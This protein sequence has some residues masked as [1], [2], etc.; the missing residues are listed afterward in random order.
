[1]GINFKKVAETS[2]GSFDPLPEN[3]YI[4]TVENAELKTA[5]TGNEMIGVQFN[6][7]DGEF[8]GRKLWHNF[9]LTPKSYVYLFNF[10]KAAGSDL[11]TKD[12]VEPTELAD[13]MLG[14]T[15]SAYVEVRNNNMGNAVNS[16]S[17]F[18]AAGGT[19]TGTQASVKNDL[20]Q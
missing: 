7:A 5:S 3:R 16:M 6:V 11:I 13:S 10:L 17:K 19:V 9:T 1:M 8:K 18:T 4:V 15:V 2:S 12:D 20:F 14:M